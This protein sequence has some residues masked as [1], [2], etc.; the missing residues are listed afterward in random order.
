[1]LKDYWCTKSIAYHFWEAI[2]KS[3]YCYRNIEKNIIIIVNQKLFRILGHQKYFCLLYCMK[4][5]WIM[6]VSFPIILSTFLCVQ[7]LSFLNLQFS[8]TNFGQVSICHEMYCPFSFFSPYI[9]L[10][11]EN[12][13]DIL[14]LIL[15]LYLVNFKMHFLTRYC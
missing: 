4:Y 12:K 3:Q 5:E 7:K 1:M 2:E 14:V 8:C 6:I 10:K 11:G 15:I 13:S 9:L